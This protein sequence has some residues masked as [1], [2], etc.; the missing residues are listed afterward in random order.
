[1]RRAV[2]PWPTLMIDALTIDRRL[3]D[4]GALCTANV[5][6]RP[7]ANVMPLRFRRSVRRA[8]L[9]RKRRSIRDAD[10]LPKARPA[11]ER[12]EAPSNP[13]VAYAF[14]PYAQFLLLVRVV[15]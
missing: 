2:A 6:R 5:G 13:E 14:K 7:T 8:T 9:E 15:T 3:Q 1:M 12:P 10:V 4:H 11:P